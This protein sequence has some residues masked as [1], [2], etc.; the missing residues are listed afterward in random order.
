[1]PK[2]G[3]SVFRPYVVKHIDHSNLLLLAIN[4]NLPE[5]T[6]YQYNNGPNPKEIPYNVSLPCYIAIKNTYTRKS[7]MSCFKKDEKVLPLQIKQIL[8][9][10]NVAFNFNR[11]SIAGISSERKQNILWWRRYDRNVPKRDSKLS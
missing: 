6:E 2:S 8:L 10:K 1:M 9:L 5:N 3:V 4:A 7:Y 11:F